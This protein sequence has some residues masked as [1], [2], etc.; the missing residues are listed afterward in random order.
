MALR[1]Y[2]QYKIKVE[3]QISETLPATCD[4]V[5]AVMY[6]RSNADCQKDI[7]CIIFFISDQGIVEIVWQITEAPDVC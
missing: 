6:G 2:A 3:H 5:A 1:S 7:Y 4:P